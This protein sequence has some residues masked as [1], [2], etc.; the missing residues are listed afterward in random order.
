MHI[1]HLAL[2]ETP[3]QASTGWS[4]TEALFT[5]VFP[6]VPLLAWA[7][8]QQDCLTEREHMDGLIRLTTHQTHQTRE[9]SLAPINCHKPLTMV[10]L[11]SVRQEDLSSQSLACHDCCSSRAPTTRSRSSTQYP[12]PIKT[13]LHISYHILLVA[14]PTPHNT[15]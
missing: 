10:L 1:T 2:L 14:F 8:K 12:S 7:A 6:S 15:D 4:N 3:S 9:A 13:R 5:H 11:G